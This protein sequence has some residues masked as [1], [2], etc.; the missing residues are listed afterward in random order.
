MFQPPFIVIDTEIASLWNTLGL[1]NLFHLK[2]FVRKLLISII[3]FEDTVFLNISV[4]LNID[5]L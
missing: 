5:T 2:I 3:T 4:A 1:V